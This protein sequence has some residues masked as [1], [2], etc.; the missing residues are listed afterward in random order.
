MSGTKKVNRFL[1]PD[2][3]AAETALELASERLALAAAA[4][5]QSFLA[6]VGGW[7]AP[8]RAAVAALAAL[9]CL[10]SLAAV[11]ANAGRAPP[12]RPPPRPP[13]VADAGRST[14]RSG[15]HGK[16]WTGLDRARASA[17]PAR[18]RA[19][20]PQD[21]ACAHCLPWLPIGKAPT[22]QACRPTA[23]TLIAPA[24]EGQK[25]QQQ[26]LQAQQLQQQP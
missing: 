15:A 26:S 4:A 25:P 12:R 13:P 11:A 1:P 21:A 10:H 3:K 16:R 6:E 14:E 23:H 22:A 20:L 8:M 9:D 7:Y 17:L 2:V 24:K 19:W 5:W 18:L